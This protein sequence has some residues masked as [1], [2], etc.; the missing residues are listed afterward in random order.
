MKAK[1]PECPD[2]R[3]KA[4]LIISVDWYMVL[5]INTM[6]EVTKAVKLQGIDRNT[7][8]ELDAPYTKASNEDATKFYGCS[9][10]SKH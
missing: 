10:F 2:E 9:S 4:K 5:I 8:V 6:N 3:Y 1:G 7:E